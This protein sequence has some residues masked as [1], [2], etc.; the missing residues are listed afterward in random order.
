[1][2]CKYCENEL[3]PNAAGTCPFCG[4]TLEANEYPVV[5]QPVE[6]SQSDAETIEVSC[7]HC[8]T[9]YTISPQEWGKKRECQICHKLFPLTSGELTQDQQAL[10][11]KNRLLQIVEK[12]RNGDE[13]LFL[14][15]QNTGN[16]IF[17]SGEVLYEIV[18]N[19][20]LSET[21]GIRRR[22]SVR[23][24]ERRNIYL[25]FADRKLGEEYEFGGLSE[26]SS[27]HEYRA[28]DI[29]DLYLTNRRVLFVGNQMQRQVELEQI[30]SFVPDFKLKGEVKIGE[31]GKQK[32]LRFSREEGLRSAAFFRYSL[33]LKALLDA[34]L[35]KF[36]LTAPADEVATYF[37]QS[38]CLLEWIL[39]P[40]E[41]SSPLD[42]R[43]TEEL[44]KGQVVLGILII[45]FMFVLFFINP[46]LLICGLLVLGFILWICW[47]CKRE[48]K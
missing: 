23:H 7:P 42:G 47:R 28:L 8:Q 22:V 45:G 10:I 19:V 14:P 46:E 20:E 2:K 9:V 25:P 26:E 39:S 34:E 43:C 30:V 41:L 21:Q 33:V 38:T 15:R 35:K 11:D 24:S 40:T 37:A 31:E 3:P 44:G 12:L 32:I 4:A 29:G 1:M 27:D 16:V 5:E 17:K 18:E 36:L 48:A 13:A 6:Q